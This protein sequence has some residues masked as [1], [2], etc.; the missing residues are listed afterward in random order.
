MRLIPAEYRIT[1]I[2][3]DAK[4]KERIRK[5]MLEGINKGFWIGPKCCYSDTPKLGKGLWQIG[6]QNPEQVEDFLNNPNF[7]GLSPNGGYPRWI[8]DENLEE[9]VIVYDPPYKGAPEF[10]YKQFI[11]TVS[12]TRDPGAVQIEMIL[13][14]AKIRLLETTQQNQIIHI[15]ME[16]DY[17]AP[18]YRG[19]RTLVFGR[20]YFKSGIF[21]QLKEGIAGEV[22][23]NQQED[24][25]FISLC[26]LLAS[27]LSGYS[28][29]N[30][31]LIGSC[32]MQAMQ[33][34]KLADEMLEVLIEPS[35]LQMAKQIEEIVFG[36]WWVP[37]FE[38]PHVMRSLDAVYGLETLEFQGSRTAE[39]D[40][41]YTLLFDAK[42]HEEILSL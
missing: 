40:I 32:I 24:N 42:G 41:E 33:K 25:C 5:L 10:A 18:R 22:P 29:I 1:Q 28:I 15:R 2:V 20:S 21:T 4:D 19:R 16:I 27:E 38:L 14:T 11:F 9:I 26:H 34:G 8:E 13:G 23:S 31:E 3:V 7:L 39:G 35:A 30:E 17:Y 37:P 12:C 36:I 6:I